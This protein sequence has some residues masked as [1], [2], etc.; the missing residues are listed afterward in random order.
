MCLSP[1][2]HEERSDTEL[3]T[4]VD[5]NQNRVYL[6]SRCTGKCGINTEAEKK[7]GERY[8]RKFMYWIYLLLG[9]KNC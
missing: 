5:D 3:N 9:S 1:D 8:L 4:A 2:T 6:P 7:N